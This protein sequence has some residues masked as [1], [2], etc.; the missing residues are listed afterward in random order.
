MLQS[1]HHHQA[2]ALRKGQHFQLDLDETD[3]LTLL[4]RGRMLEVLDNLLSNAVKYAPK[5]AEIEARTRICRE[6][7]CIEFSLYN[8]GVGLS[9]EDKGRIF[10]KFSRLSAR[11]TGGESSTGLGLSIARTLTEMHGGSI[12]A[13]SEG[14]DRGVRFIMQLPVS[15]IA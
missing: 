8:P 15:R 7:S 2:E 4:D 3:M 12:T 14:I 5:G 1:I 11:P 13:E 9:E 10:Q 6:K